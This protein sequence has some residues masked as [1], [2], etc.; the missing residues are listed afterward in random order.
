MITN[1]RRVV[2]AEGESDGVGLS[3]MAATGAI[4]RP[5]F[6]PRQDATLQQLKL[7]TAPRPTGAARH[8]AVSHVQVRA[9]ARPLRHAPDRPTAP[10]VPRPSSG[11]AAASR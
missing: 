1:G 9:C 4:M 6:G 11:R 2:A 8:I 7:R 3:G 10:A 5:R